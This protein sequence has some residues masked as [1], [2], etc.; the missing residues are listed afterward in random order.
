MKTVIVTGVGGPAGRNVSDLLVQQNLHVIGVDMHPVE[1]TGG[2]FQQVPAALDDRFIDALHAIAKKARPVL[3]IPTV[4]EELPVLASDWRWNKDMPLLLSTAE[5]IHIAND[6]YLTCKL[7]AERDISVPRF[8]L[9][10]KLRSPDELAD[11][12]GWP[13]I[14]KP[15]T[16]R[17]GRGVA[18]REKGDFSIVRSLGDEYI[19]QEFA[20][21]T[22]FAPNVY[23]GKDRR[24]TVVVLEKMV[25]KEGRVGNALAVRR[26]IAPDVAALATEAALA[27]DLRG[28][29][30]V[31]IRR[32]QDGTPVVLE[33]NARFG[34][35]IRYAPEV[36]ERVIAEYLHD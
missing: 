36:L 11:Q 3:I 27:L 2:D 35:N 1:M 34:A 7:L 25:L 16:G 33:I 13:C 26:V 24:G 28:P 29:V 9:P 6:K 22:D 20:D 4:T 32:L 17:G 30:D 8:A 31:D 12:I 10:S 21:G 18:I 14:T 23:I 5:G 19:V 15:R